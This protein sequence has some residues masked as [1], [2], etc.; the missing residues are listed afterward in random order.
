VPWGLRPA[1]SAGAAIVL[2]ILV[3][4]FAVELITA[5]GQTGLAERI[6]GAAQ[7]LW[8]LAVVVSCGLAARTATG[9]SPAPVAPPSFN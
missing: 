9:P 4:W 3:T 1:V 8:P 5:G 6:F 2:L 7:A